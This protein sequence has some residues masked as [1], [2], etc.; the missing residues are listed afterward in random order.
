MIFRIVFLL[1]LVV[2]SLNIPVVLDI[3]K[4]N[5]VEKAFVL[6]AAILIA[7]RG[8]IDRTLA[9]CALVIVF[10]TFISAA[11]TDYSAFSWDLYARA[12]ITMVAALLFLVTIPREDDR[13]FVLKLLTL[14]APFQVALG[15]V[16]GAIGIWSVFKSD[17][18]G[19]VRLAGTTGPAFLA[20]SAMTG[21]VA[22]LAY[23]SQRDL[24][25]LIALGANVIILMLSGGRMA[26]AA[27]ALGCAG[28]LFFGFRRNR[29]AKFM[30]MIGGG[31]A[32]AILV[33]LLGSTLLD[34][35]VSGSLQGRELLWSYLNGYI[36][37]YPWFGVGL[38]AQYTLIP[39]RITFLTGTVAAHNEY[40]RFQVELGL[41]GGLIFL[42]G[43]LAL[44]AAMFNSPACVNRGGYLAIVL[45]LLIFS[46]TDNTLTRFESI[47]MLVVAAYGTSRSRGTSRKAPAPRRLGD[48]YPLPRHVP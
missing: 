29:T 35:A 45:A 10:G 43:F 12:L 2:I 14:V 11:L 20:M 16:Y 39:S 44:F 25:Y 7:M 36:R 32:A 8:R 23:A 9:G 18:L 37:D 17:S 19:V 48:L 6:L 15:F 27:A 3:E 1:S 21:A 33:P 28:L 22:S 40:I 5:P 46:A 47:A 4:A 31:L 24:R 41:V 30:I 13:D 34:R 38:G 26:T 42:C